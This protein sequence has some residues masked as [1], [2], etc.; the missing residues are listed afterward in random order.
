MRQP[1]ITGTKYGIIPNRL[2]HNP[3]IRFFPPTGK[4]AVQNLHADCRTVSRIR[5]MQKPCGREWSFPPARQANPCFTYNLRSGRRL[6]RRR[7]CHLQ[8]QCACARPRYPITRIIHKIESQRIR[9]AVPCHRH[10]TFDYRCGTD[11]LILDEPV[12]PTA[13]RI[14]DAVGFGA[15]KYRERFLEFSS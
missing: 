12:I 3:K 10:G 2:N 15:G 6:R 9:F 7:R 13:V 14:Y 5:H 1:R 8:L 4:P 11:I